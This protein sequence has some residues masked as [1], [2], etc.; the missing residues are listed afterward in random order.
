MRLAVSRTPRARGRM[1]R[2][3]VSMRISAGIRGTGV[4]SGRRCPR[5]A[6]GFFRNPIITVINQR[7]TASAMF[8][9]SW[10][11]GVNVYGRRPSILIETKKTIKDVNIRAHLCPPIFSGRR[12]CWV[13]RLIN[14]P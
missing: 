13:N 1:K 6:V 12:S 10:V 9:E 8:R 14:Q 2:L 7:G 3:M 5:A 11:V 4:P